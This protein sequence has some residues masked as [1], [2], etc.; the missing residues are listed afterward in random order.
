MTREQRLEAALKEIEAAALS[1]RVGWER[2]MPR[3]VTNS[4]EA[5]E[6]ACQ[7]ALTEPPSPDERHKQF[8]E[9]HDKRM[10]RVDEAI[11]EVRAASPDT[12]PD[13]GLTVE[14]ARHILDTG[15]LTF[16]AC[17]VCGLDR[18]RV[19]HDSLIAKIRAALSQHGSSR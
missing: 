4:L 7:S 19:D 9:Q 1:T 2:H 15:A 5:I 17:A 16:A 3:G 6:R 11:E 12:L 8:L 13:P 18:S 10:Q 14:E